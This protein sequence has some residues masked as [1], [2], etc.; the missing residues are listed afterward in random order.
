MSSTNENPTLVPYSQRRPSAARGRPIDAKRRLSPYKERPRHK[1]QH[2]IALYGG[3]IAGG[4]GVPRA[5]ADTDSGVRQRLGRRAEAGY[6]QGGR[7]GAAGVRAH[8]RAGLTRRLSPTWK[9]EVAAP[10]L[11]YP[12]RP[13]PGTALPPWPGARSWAWGGPPPGG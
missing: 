11:C 5:G 7:V 1:R 6:R 10:A 8:G 12:A 13:G 2:C 4:E 3:K 9:E